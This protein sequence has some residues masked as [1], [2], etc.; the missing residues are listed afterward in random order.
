[1]PLIDPL[2]PTKTHRLDLSPLC[3]RS[4][5]TTA[6]TLPQQALLRLREV[7]QP[8]SLQILGANFLQHITL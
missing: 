8:L 2:F 6:P 7:L 5:R 3:H 4:E 1:M